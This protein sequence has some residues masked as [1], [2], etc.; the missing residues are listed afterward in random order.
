MEE[1]IKKP[2][3]SALGR[4]LSALISQTAVPVAFDAP[5][6]DEGAVEKVIDMRTREPVSD[7]PARGVLYIP[8]D[9]IVNNPAQP[10]QDFKEAELV[11]LAASIKRLGV[12]QPLV[13][14]RVEGSGQFEIVAGERRWRASKL[15]GVAQVPAVV[16]ELSE[17][18]ALEI[19]IVENV[20]RENLNPIEQATAYQRLIQ[21]F[22]LSQEEVAEQVGKDRASISNILRLLKLPKEV[23]SYLQEGKLTLGHAKAI[24]SIK[25]PNGQL[26]LAKKVLNEHLSVRALESLVSRVV[27]LDAGKIAKD[28]SEIPPGADRSDLIDTT[29]RLRRTLGTKVLMKHHATG[30]GSIVI[31]YFSEVELERIVERI[32]SN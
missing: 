21:E 32:C 30:K 6:K 14:R 26:S 20:Q 17:R 13:V 2:I 28:R 8:V 4:G 16:R 5:A 18:D 24:L 29:E 15:A 9:K 25:D 11:E 10:R 12:L 3:R 1:K 23:Q 19:A 27:V 7:E 31:E 22:S